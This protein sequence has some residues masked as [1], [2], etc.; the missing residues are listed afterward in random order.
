MQEDPDSG[1]TASSDHLMQTIALTASRS[2]VEGDMNWKVA[3]VLRRMSVVPRHRMLV[4]RDPGLAGLT[5]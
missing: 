4:R 1:A 5:T 2:G 3:R